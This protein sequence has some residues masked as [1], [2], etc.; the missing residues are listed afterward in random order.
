M[1]L[2]CLWKVHE[3]KPRGQ[4]ETILKIRRG[5]KFLVVYLFLLK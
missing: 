5:F 4:E 1:E 3:I 2:G